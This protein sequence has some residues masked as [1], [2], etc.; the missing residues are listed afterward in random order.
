MCLFECCTS[1]DLAKLWAKKKV[2]L[3]DV[4]GGIDEQFIEAV[5]CH[6]EKCT[7]N[8]LM[9]QLVKMYP[10]LQGEQTLF[11]LLRVC[12]HFMNR[13]TAELCY[14]SQRRVRNWRY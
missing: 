9:T 1:L 2:G 5:K 4:S 10:E 7:V 11:I 8:Y 6:G 14:S 13:F 3:Y 12:N